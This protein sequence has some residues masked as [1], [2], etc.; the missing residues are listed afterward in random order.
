MNCLNQN[1]IQQYIDGEASPAE[2]AQIKKHIEACEKCGAS[3]DKQKKRAN[4]VKRAI[5][6]LAE[7]AAE[8]PTITLP[9]E[10][11]KK[12]FFNGRRILYAIAAACILLFIILISRN[13][14]MEIQPMMT[15]EPGFASDID[16]N[17]PV[18]Q[19]SLVITIIDSEG[20]VSEYFN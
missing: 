13:K 5:N 15:I 17:R 16:A 20:N 11:I 3:I 14:D 10:H 19:Q 8:A 9:S 18:S 12:N 2:V 1:I 4:G 7:D 6:L